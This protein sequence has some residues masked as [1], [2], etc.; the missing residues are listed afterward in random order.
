MNRNCPILQAALKGIMVA[1]LAVSVASCGLIQKTTVSTPPARC[2]D[3]VPTSWAEGVPGAPVPSN[4]PR[5]AEW[6]G[7]PLTAAMVAAIIAPWAGAYVTSE[8]QISK[9]NG[10]TVDTVGIVKRCEEMVNAARADRQ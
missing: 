6:L 8:G 10:R 4:E 3:L 9:A 2:A 5:I 1:I 7:K